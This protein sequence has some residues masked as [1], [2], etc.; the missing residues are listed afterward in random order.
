M[1]T[2]HIPDMSCGHCLATVEKAIHTLDPEAQ[3]DFDMEARRIELDSRA[4]AADVRS[5][6]AAAGYSATT[7]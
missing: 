3:I 6:L 4:T 2:F 7:A 1:D 5:V